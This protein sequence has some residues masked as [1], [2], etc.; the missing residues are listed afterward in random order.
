[1]LLFA[2][3]GTPK[4]QLTCEANEFTENSVLLKVVFLSRFMTLVTYFVDATCDTKL[5]RRKTSGNHT[6]M[7]ICS[8]FKA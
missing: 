3:N 7:Y 8:S 6:G 4:P 2:K 5:G 1:M